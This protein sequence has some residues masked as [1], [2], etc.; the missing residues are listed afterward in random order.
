MNEQSVTAQRADA[1]GGSPGEVVA[2]FSRLSVSC[3]G[4]P[5]AHLGYFHDE[6]VVRRRWLDEKTFVDLVALAAFLLLFT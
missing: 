5:I 3:F 6:F 1:T 2:V 4:G